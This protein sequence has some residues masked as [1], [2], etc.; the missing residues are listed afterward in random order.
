MKVYRILPNSF[1]LNI[2]NNTDILGELNYQGFEDFY[3]QMELV[4]FQ[5]IMN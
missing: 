1:S 2:G 4:S 5:K 3:Y